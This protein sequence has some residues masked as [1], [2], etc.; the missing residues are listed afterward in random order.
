MRD[1][2]LLQRDYYST[3]ADQ[4]DRMHNSSADSHAFALAVL[5]SMIDFFGFQSI[6][7]VGAGTGR[8]LLA[9]KRSHPAVRLVG[10][11]PSPEMRSQG[12]TKGLAG[13]ELIDGDAQALPFA[14]GSFDLVCEFGVLHHIPKPRKA[15]YEM[16]RVARKG[17]FISDG[18]NF[19]QGSFLSRCAKQAI[20]A[21]GF[22][23]VAN[24]IKT[25]G[26]GYVISEGDGLAYSYSVFNDYDQIKALCKRIH[27]INT[28]G[29]GPN[30]YRSA[31]HVALLGLK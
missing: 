7:D 6:L 1:P 17:I 15:V 2:V 14:D 29:S 16:L 22:W 10:I 31:P 11:E 4:Y 24:L 12:H 19:G 20:D 13:T 23:A 25:R 8:A 5:V 28:E 9:I 26:R 18:N 27:L 3:T 21:F 30:L